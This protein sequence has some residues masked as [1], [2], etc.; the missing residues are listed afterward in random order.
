M[1]FVSVPFLIEYLE[2]TQWVIQQFNILSKI[3]VILLKNLIVNKQFL[4]N[5]EVHPKPL[6]ALSMIYD[7]ITTEQLHF[8]SCFS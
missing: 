2:E 3:N 7:D 5:S 6:M 1:D 4:A 8:L